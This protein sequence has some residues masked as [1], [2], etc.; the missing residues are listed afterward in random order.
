MNVLRR[1][2][3]E[4][5]GFVIS[6]EAIVILTMIICAVVVGWQ[7]IRMAVVTE[8]ADIAEAIGAINQSY[9]YVGFRGHDAT[10][11]GSSY[12]DGV[13]FCDEAIACVQVGSMARCIDL[14][15][16]GV[17]KEQN[18]LATGGGNGAGAP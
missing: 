16:P 7:A 1:L 3:V 15:D 14:I 6:T 9:S 11:A 18:G 17:D 5:A 8:L 12:D 4:D 10:C 13:D 2:W